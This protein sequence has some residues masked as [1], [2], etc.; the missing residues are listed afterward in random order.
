MA[1]L[2]LGCTPPD[3]TP[4]FEDGPLP[5]DTL[6]A[7]SLIND[8]VPDPVTPSEP[9]STVPGPSPTPVQPPPG[10]VVVTPV[11]TECEPDFN[12]TVN[13]DPVTNTLRNND[14][15]VISF[16]ACRASDDLEA[17]AKQKLQFGGAAPGQGHAT[18]SAELRKAFALPSDQSRFGSDAVDLSGTQIDP[19]SLVR[20]RSMWK[21]ER[22]DLNAF[23][24]HQRQW[25][26]QRATVSF[27]VRVKPNGGHAQYGANLT[28][29]YVCSDAVLYEN[30][31]FGKR[32]DI[33]IPGAKRQISPFYVS[34]LV[35]QQRLP[36]L[37]EAGGDVAGFVAE[38]RQTQAYKQYGEGAI[39]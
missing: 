33:L 34:V 8:G 4:V 32:V 24:F 10:P 15:V 21:V 23:E 13:G 20:G 17:E 9:D 1:V 5:A 18:V 37:A 22:Q 14:K 29:R 26:V 39:F 31:R 11:P 7:D 16:D 28:M 2:L 27:T 30:C 12:I 3:T 25:M 6:D 35:R 19:D 36:T 38:I